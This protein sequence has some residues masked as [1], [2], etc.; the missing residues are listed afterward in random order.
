M[1]RKCNRKETLEWDCRDEENIVTEEI[2]YRVGFN[3][4]NLIT[5]MIL[6]QIG[7]DKM[8]RIILIFICVLSDFIKCTRNGF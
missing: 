4:E 5:K 2:I 7:I 8:K 1:D 3:N 6:D